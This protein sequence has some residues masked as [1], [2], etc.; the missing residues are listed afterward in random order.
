MGLKCKNCGHEIIKRT[1]L[2][3][4]GKTWYEH[5]PS[6]GLFGLSYGGGCIKPEQK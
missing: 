2:N 1:A 3:G 6:N 4:S 5:T